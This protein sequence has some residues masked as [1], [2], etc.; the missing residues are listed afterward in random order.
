MST[1]QLIFGLIPGAAALAMLFL[2]SS[3]FSG[4]RLAGRREFGWLAVTAGLWCLFA[5]LEYLSNNPIVRI[6]FAKS[7]YLGATTVPVAWVVFAANYVRWG[8][9]LKPSVIAAM[10]VVP[11]ITLILAFTNEWHGLM[12][13][14]V[15][16][17][18]EPI[19][20]F[21]IEHGWWFRYGH[22]PYSYA[23]I[24]FG[25]SILVARFFSDFAAY[26]R[27][28]IGL[29]FSSA[30]ILLVNVFYTLANVSLY[31]L[32]PTPI[33]ASLMLL[34]L[35]W[36]LFTDLLKVPPL[37]YR[38]VFMNTG[39]AVVLLGPDGRV[40]E[41]N[42][43]AQRIVGGSVTVG[44]PVSKVLPWLK[45]P[46]EQAGTIP[47]EGV[48]LLRNGDVD[49][50]NLVFEVMYCPVRDK[51]TAVHGA[52]VLLRDVT[53]RERERELLEQF[54]RQDGLT[55][56]LN[57]R[58]FIDTV[59]QRLASRPRS[60][61]L[62]LLFVDLNRFKQINDQFGHA[63]G[64]EVLRETTR[65]I[66]NALR[67]GDVMGR[68]GGDEFAVLIDRAEQIEPSRLIKRLLA[69]FETPLV[70]AGNQLRISASMGFAQWPDDG[71]TVRDM[72]AAADQRMYAQKG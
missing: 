10:L 44:Q 57:H 50:A 63:A 8:A 11:V 1:L 45:L 23:L 59:E 26:R 31:G 39:D 58:A 30:S 14:R 38:A 29:V 34:G 18:S 20:D 68:L 67:P 6:W 40:I 4:Q 7:I 17:V 5:S 24:L 55:Q 66:S 25:L 52:A 22:M 48:T 72:L 46:V 54:A 2:A 53:V 65:R 27:Q 36:S 41:C 33:I 12:W 69:T 42:P 49:G 35:A 51:G 47:I 56:A 71:D 19:P 21:Q 9:W 32:D 70:I 60:R 61:P 64:D 15:T 16:F 28:I 13:Q 3:A 37:S 43:T 62:A